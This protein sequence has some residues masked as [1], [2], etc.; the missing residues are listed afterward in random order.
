MLDRMTANLKTVMA[1][2]GDAYFLTASGTGAMEMSDG[3]VFAFVTSELTDPE[4]ILLLETIR[5]N[6]GYKWSYSLVRF[7]GYRTYVRYN[8]KDIWNSIPIA[9]DHN[10]DH[11]YQ[12]LQQPLVEETW[13]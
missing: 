12:L 4:V 13:R 3:A 9:I 6:G 7:S 1:T 8:G 10:E 5:V 2:S 11:T